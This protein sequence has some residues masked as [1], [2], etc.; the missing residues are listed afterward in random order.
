MNKKKF[1][2]D[3]KIFV[4]GHNGMAGSSIIRSLNKKGYN[5]IIFTDKNQLDLRDT[6]KVKEWFNLNKPD[7]VIDAAAKVGGILANK[8]LPAD[9]LFDNL[10]IQLNIIETAWE[11]NVKRLLFLGSSCIYPKFAKQPIKEEYLL[12]GKLE[13]TNE[14]YAIAKIA[15]IKMCS[16][17]GEQYGFDAISAMPTNLYGPGDNYDLESSHVL[18][19]LIRRFYEAK[20]NKKEEVVCWGSGEPLREFLHVD[21]LGD[22]CVFLLENWYPSK[23]QP[24]FI[25]VGTGI[26]ISIK[27]LA[28]RISKIINYS[29]N[30]I[31]DKNKPDGTLK[32][33]LDISKMKN[34]GWESKISLQEGLE[35]TIKDFIN[36]LEKQN[37]RF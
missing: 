19:A 14:S 21:D 24:K 16:S 9:F 4:A 13:K 18:P 22:A 8:N 11:N 28:L 29:G 10:K 26:D 5:K 6:L 25:N 3:D 23:D 12:D 30:I 37:L 31:W 35:R 27:D 7:V 2:L 32:K 34:L 36:Q 1:N 17:L 20:I 15:G 33:Q